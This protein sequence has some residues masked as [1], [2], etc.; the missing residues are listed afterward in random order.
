MTANGGLLEHIAS[1][2]EVGAI[3]PFVD[4]VF[5]FE[6]TNEA[7]AYIETGRA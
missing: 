7:L 4:R 3:R 1:L 5:P 6:K 2:I